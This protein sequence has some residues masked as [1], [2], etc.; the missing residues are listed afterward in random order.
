MSK[1]NLTP[2]MFEIVGTTLQDQEKISRPSLTFWKDAWVRL[3]KNKGALVGLVMVTLI[4]LLAIFAPMVSPYDYKEQDP[5]LKT[6]YLPPKIPVLENVSWLPFDGEMADIT[7]ATDEN[8]DPVMI[9]YYAE[10]GEED[11]HYFGTDEFGRDI[12]TRVWYGAR[13]SIAIGILA[14][15]I[16][17]CIGVAYGGIS[18][19]FGGKVDIIM[20]RFSEIL[21]GIPFLVIVILMMLVLGPGFWSI[22]FAMVVTGWIGMSRI[23]RGQFLKL[24]NQEYVMAATTLGASS[25]RIILKH[26]LPNSLG[27]LIISIMFTIPSAIF[28]ESF[29]SFIGLGI[30]APQASLGSLVSDALPVLFI[31]P[32]MLIIPAIILS[33]L[34][35]SFNLIADGLRDAIDPKMRK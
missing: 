3:K 8:G 2:E 34:I 5:T 4:I 7:G 20:Q 29:L 15:L 25:S 16:D 31:Y 13:I 19:Y 27:P 6:Q 26:L 10:T 28:F 14:A 24:K 1:Q 35:L 22:V 33:V 11:Y 18:G 17:F 12:W 21:I 32:Y 30:P 9:D 23:V